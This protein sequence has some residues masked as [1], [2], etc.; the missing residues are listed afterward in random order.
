MPESTKS[1][2]AAVDC[3]FELKKVANAE[4][5]ESVNEYRKFAS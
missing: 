5:A 2:V 1:T 3:S 4:N